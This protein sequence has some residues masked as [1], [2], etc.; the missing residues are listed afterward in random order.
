MSTECIFCKIINGYIFARIIT[1][2]DKAIAFLDAFPLTLGHTLI[3]PKSHY[4]KIQDMDKD[5]SSAVFDLLWKLC[6]A[7]EKAVESNAA[8]IAIHN[9]KDAGQEVPH[10]HAH[11]IPRTVDDGAG[12]VHSMFKNRKKI[13]SKELDVTLNNIKKC[14]ENY[15]Y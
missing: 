14:V 5:H 9:G 15:Y 1:H 4:Y 8:T 3:I 2:N 11:I 12:P 13:S 10:V 6:A 7:I